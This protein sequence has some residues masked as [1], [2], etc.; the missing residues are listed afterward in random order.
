MS[1]HHQHERA[2]VSFRTMELVVALVIFVFGAIVIYDS[3]RVGASGPKT[4]QGGYFPFYIGLLTC[5]SASHHLRQGRIRRRARRK[6][7]V[8]T[9]QLSMVLQLFVRP[10]CSSA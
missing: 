7:F 5:L 1:E 2:A 3:V 6:A 10:S 8:T 9:Q 4:A